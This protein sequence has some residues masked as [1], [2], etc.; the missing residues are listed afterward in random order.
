MTFG[1]RASGRRHRPATLLWVEPDLGT[2]SGGLRYNQQLR[3]ALH[4]QG[5]RNPV[6]SLPGDWNEPLS[7]DCRALTEQVDEAVSRHDVDAVVIDGLIGSACPEL[8]GKASSLTRGTPRILL[9]HLSAAVALEIHASPDQET[10]GQE[11]AGQE[12]VQRERLAVHEAD[13]VLTVSHWSAAELR[14][15]YRRQDIRVA[16]P[17]AEPP[18]A[19]APAC[20]ST[21]PRLACVS[22]FLPVKN[23]RL[24][25]DALE[26]LLDLDWKLTLAGPHHHSDYGREVVE[27]LQLRLPGRIVL[28]GMLPPTEVRELWEETDLLLLPSSVETYG[29]VVTEACAHGV[30]AFVPAGTGA[31]EAAADAGVALEPH[32]PEQWTAALRDWMTQETTRGELQDRARRRQEQLPAWEAAAQVLRELISEEKD[33]SA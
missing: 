15:R 31:E 11:S 17:G 22:A 32:R 10:A 30:P 19:P 7:T 5:L 14:R 2:V 12:A 23:H 28:R 16:V 13:H 3:Q 9:V 21:T 25:G 18:A 6:L 20:R 4:S 1:R 29:M 27:E 8:F 33:E 26:P 24:L